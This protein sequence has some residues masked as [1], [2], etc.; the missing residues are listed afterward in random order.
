VRPTPTLVPLAL[1]IV[2]GAKAAYA[3]PNAADKETA[4]RLM[5]E[6]RE[7]REA[8]DYQTA[9]QSFQAADAIM[10]VPTTGVEVARTEILLGQLVEARDKLL[11]VVRFPKAPREP[12]PFAEARVAAAAM[13]EEIAPRVPSLKIVV[14][15]APDGSTVKVSVDGINVATE[16]LLEPR[17]V[18]PG[19]HVVIARV[20][21]GARR[22]AAVDL[23]EGTIQE[24]ILAL[25]QS[26]VAQTPPPV[27]PGPA[28]PPSAPPS[29]SHTIA[30]LGF[31][32]AGA[33]I[34]TGAVT[35]L[36][37]MSKLNAARTGGCVGNECPP[38]TYPALDSAGTLATVSTVGFIVGGAG[39]ALGVIGLF[40]GGHGSSEE[41]PSARQ[42]TPWIGAGSA[43]VR[44]TF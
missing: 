32:V 36:L 38:S 4:R 35:G 25:P 16:S 43:G 12:R 34:A 1:C 13:S 29:R 3:D 22:E 18:N 14:H 41:S 21:G 15:G 23:R 44:G 9:L 31:S 42:L 8:R 2:L 5:A 40:V 28:P 27:P 10:Q 6:G 24:V 33:G 17:A 19:H 39:A 20:V 7:R 11:A 37:A 26:A 30:I